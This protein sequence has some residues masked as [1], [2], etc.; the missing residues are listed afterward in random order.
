MIVGDRTNASLGSEGI[1]GVRN[2]LIKIKSAPLEISEIPQIR[3]NSNMIFYFAKCYQNKLSQE[4]IR[5]PATIL[6]KNCS[7]NEIRA[8]PSAGPA[9]GR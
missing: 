4:S 7:P 6:E 5:D 8:N 2:V 9:I 1:R 3:V